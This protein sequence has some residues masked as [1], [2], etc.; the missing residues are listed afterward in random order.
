VFALFKIAVIV[1]QIYRRWVDGHTRDARFGTLIGWVRV[2]AGQ[3]ARALERGRIH[4]LGPVA[5]T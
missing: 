1:Q 4:A 5:R 2:L 3:A